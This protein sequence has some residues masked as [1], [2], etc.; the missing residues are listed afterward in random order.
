MIGIFSEVYLVDG[1]IIRKAPRS[2]SEEDL[3]PI[4]REATI[5][6]LLNDHPHI[7]QCTSRGRMDYIDIKYYPHGDLSSFCQKNEVTPELRSKWFQQLLEAVAVIH[8]YDIIHSDLALRQFFVDDGLNIRLGD[9]NSS[10]YPGHPALG[11]EKTTHCLPRDYE[12]PNTILSDTF[13][14]GSTLY[15]LLTGKA[16]YTDLY[17]VEPEDIVRSSDPDVIRARFQRQQLA[18]LEVEQRYKNH[19]F[20]DVSH[21]FRGDIILGFWNGRITSVEEALALYTHTPY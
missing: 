4:I 10:Q 18:D 11:Y 12:L 7:A 16:P 19:E 6:N 13:A 2:G 9:F 21:L 8:S 3:Q 5:Y 14:L 1:T 20:P 15:E 17:P